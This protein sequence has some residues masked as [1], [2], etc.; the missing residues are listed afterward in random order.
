MTDR[1]TLPLSLYL[2]L[3]WCVSRCPYCDF[4]AH[5]AR[6][7]DEERYVDAL[8]AQLETL[9]G[10]RPLTS[11]FFGGGTPSR[12]SCAA[13][14]RIL[15]CV[16]SRYALEADLEITIEAN[17]E[18]SSQ[19]K[20]EGYR[21]AG[22][23]RVSIGVQSFSGRHL[24]VLGRAHDPQG[25]RSAVEA[26]REAGF[27]RINIDLMY[28]LPGQTCEDAM[29]DLA[30]AL[31][32]GVEH[33]SWYQLTLEPGT[34]FAM[35]PPAGLP[36]A[37]AAFDICERGEAMLADAGFAQYE[38]SA[39]SLPGAHCRHNVNYWEYGD[40]LGVGAGARGK[41]TREDRTV[42]RMHQTDDPGQ[43]MERVEACPECAEV[44]VV[45][46][47][48]RIFEFFLNALRLRAGFPWRM[49]EERTGCA[50]DAPEVREALGKAREEGL[51]EEEPGWLR[52]S[53]FGY[54]HLDDLVELFLPGD[55]PR[56]HQQGIMPAPRGISDHEGQ[57]LRLS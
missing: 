14:A 44:S 11:I 20:F 12:F 32:L 39:W 53:R 17:P 1:S 15:S 49:F 50:R 41:R 10:S 16:R 28:G 54:R 9:P 37:D 48:D 27:R 52:A 22:V 43:W 29:A 4:N 8:C 33:I 6:S 18:S 21:A 24:K 31:D 56:A 13:I 3:P 23:N 51:V 57:R 35:R 25:A 30:R 34:L 47:R 5:A 19:E 42:L 55:A 40:Y 45:E 7:F 38:V 46:A 2:H 36:A 26:A